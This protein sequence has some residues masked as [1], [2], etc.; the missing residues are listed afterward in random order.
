MSGKDDQAPSPSAEVSEHSTVSVLAVG[1]PND[2]V[3]QEDLPSGGA[4]AF[5]TYDELSEAML[6]LYKPKIIISPA[7]TA[8]FDCIDLA[9]LL[10]TI[11]YAGA[12][13]AIASDVPNPKL[14]E[15]E[16]AQIC[17]TIDFQLVRGN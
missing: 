15:R 16:V 13:R 8:S 17:P 5:V 14:V 9:I 2:W 1:G 11:G 12:Y 7:W 10:R 6:D 4:M 3:R